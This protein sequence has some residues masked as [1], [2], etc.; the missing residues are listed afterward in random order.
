VRYGYADGEV[1][2]NAE[3]A[4]SDAYNYQ[5]NYRLTPDEVRTMRFSRT[6]LGR[7]GLSEDEVRTA[8]VRVAEDMSSSDAEKAAL[9]AEVSRLRDYFRRH[10]PEA[11][12]IEHDHR[13]RAEAVNILSQAQ[14]QADAYV[15]QALE[16]GRQVTAQA[17]H[18]AE[19]LLQDA[20]RRAEAAAESAAHEYRRQAGHQYAAQIE[21]LER[22]SAWLRTFAKAV[23]VQ[24]QSATDAFSREIEKVAAAPIPPSPDAEPTASVPALEPH[25]SVASGAESSPATT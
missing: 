13:P 14:Q 18:Q 20:Q 8:L 17:R 25:R 7:R 4:E 22:R 12:V 15:A 9:R 16:Y 21:E 6:P 10:H 24:M 1:D 5:T 11:K 23:Q 19:D 3:L 2:G